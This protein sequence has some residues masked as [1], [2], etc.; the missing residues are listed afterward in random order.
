MR[1]IR[2]AAVLG[3]GVMGAQIAALLVN[4]GI[5]CL[6]L[7]L[8]PT[9]LTADEA[10]RGLTLSNGIVRNRLSLGARRGLLTMR[11]APLYD[12]EA[13]GLITCGNFSDDMEQLAKCDWIIEAIVERFAEKHAMHEAI[14]RVRSKGAIVTTNTSGLS[15]TDLGQ[16]LSEDYR[17]HFFG[18]H[19]FNPPRYMRLLE[20]IPTAATNRAL[21]DEFSEFAQARLG[22]TV[23]RARDTPNFIANRIAVY[24]FLIT[25]E[26]MRRLSFSPHQVD[27]LT[28]AV[29]GR[30]K[31]ATFRTLDIVGLDTFGHVVETSRAGARDADE[32]HVFTPPEFMD[33]MMADGRLGDKTGM[34]FFRMERRGAERDL[35]VLDLES[36]TYGPA[37]PL[38]SPVL[39]AARQMP[40]LGRRVRELAYGQDQAAEFVWRVLA[41][42]LCYAG[43]MLGVVAD[44]AAAID[45]ALRSGYNWEAGPFELWDMLGV[46]RS[47]ERMDREGLPVPD[48]ARRAVREGGGF[49]REVEERGQCMGVDGWV[50]AHSPASGVARRLKDRTQRVF[51]N[52]GASLVDV[53]DGVACL[54]F[55]SPKNAIGADMMDMMRRAAD[56]VE[57]AY[58]GLVIIGTGPDFCVGANLAQ[59]LMEAQEGNWDEIDFAVRSFQQ[60]NLRLKRLSR[61]VVA[62][63]Y[64]RTLGGGAEICLG[65][66][67]VQAAAE[68]YCGLVEV[69]AGLIPAGGG[70]KELL[71]RSSHRKPGAAAAAPEVLLH[72]VFDQIAYA[73]V[74][75]SAREAQRMSLFGPDDGVTMNP[76]RLTMDAVQAVKRLRAS[77]VSRQP[78]RVRVLGEGGAATLRAEVFNLRHG[79]WISQHDAHVAERLIGVLTGG[80][81]GECDVSEEYLLDLERE[82][83][84][85]LCGEPLTQARMAHLLKRGKPLRN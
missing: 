70:C 37:V 25:V 14:D 13:A 73:K 21:L 51:G 26:E 78:E 36:M 10:K 33:R 2:R 52:S 42:T 85:S 27:Q 67:H 54:V 44:D 76:A 20:V 1:T 50:D 83:F 17:Q 64:G 80:A 72:G 38:R 68:T 19:F 16:D 55:H 7:D 6:L 30:P 71:L 40:D 82:A 59:I 35:Q 56:A 5:P 75:G 3:A 63:P 12:E 9:S 24:G 32:A 65:A 15:V 46:E 66:T 41:R 77:H 39:D 11:P 49:Y 45:E 53:G 74:S 79:G 62:A 69:G 43:R 58:E 22:K 31:S 23:V 18:A 28:G 4:A 61:P 47:L 48:A 84:L 34:G 57:N 81:V 8:A 60:A 29:I